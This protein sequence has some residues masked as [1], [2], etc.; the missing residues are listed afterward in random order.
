MWSAPTSYLLWAT[1]WSNIYITQK[2]FPHDI[3]KLLNIP[4][5]NGRWVDRIIQVCPTFKEDIISLPDHATVAEFWC[6]KA[7][8]IQDLLYMNRNFNIVWIDSVP[9]QE[10][11]WFTFTCG[12][13]NTPWVWHTIPNDSLDYAYSF[14]LSMYLKNPLSFLQN[15]QKKL[16]E[17][18]SALIHLW[19]N[20]QYTWWLLSLLTT[21]F[22]KVSNGVWMW[23]PVWSELFPLFLP[24]WI[25]NIYKNN[26]FIE[27]D[28]LFIKLDKHTNLTSP[29]DLHA[30]QW[31]FVKESWR[32]YKTRHS[33]N[34]YRYTI[35]EK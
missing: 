7:V 29:Y 28:P 24:D 17:N 2:K 15:I 18:W 19:Y 30:E 9:I 26:L 35:A 32:I 22:N 11:T 21:V 6:G 8:T 34:R 27:Y 5:T 1:G 3:E 25:E 16:K 4:M 33:E 13:L 20:Q 23:D 10:S 12:D 14:F 31:L